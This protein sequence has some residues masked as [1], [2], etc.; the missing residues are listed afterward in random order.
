ME[1]SAVAA[2]PAIC[3]QGTGNFRRNRVHQEKLK[4]KAGA[5]DE[6]PAPAGG[7][8]LLIVTLTCGCRLF[9][10]GFFTSVGA[11][12][13]TALCAG[14]FGVVARVTASAAA[15]VGKGR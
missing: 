13:F 6:R 9:C 5:D 8:Q 12:R 3:A 1:K 14:L 10:A 7:Q 11:F 4:Q 2:H 15:A